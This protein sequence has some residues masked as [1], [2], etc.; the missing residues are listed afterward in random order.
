MNKHRVFRTN[1][2]T[3]RYLNGQECS[4]LGPLDPSLYDAHETGPMFSVT[5]ASEPN[6][7]FHAFNDE[8]Q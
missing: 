8:L 3:L 6:R 7:I 2:T 1:D 5:F 4:I